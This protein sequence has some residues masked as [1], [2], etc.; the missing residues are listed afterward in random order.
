[1]R[2]LYFLLDKGYYFGTEKNCV[3][4]SRIKGIVSEVDRSNFFTSF[5]KV[6]VIYSSY[7]FCVLFFNI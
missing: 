6:I 7:A 3:V 2:L 1:M 5:L 4:F